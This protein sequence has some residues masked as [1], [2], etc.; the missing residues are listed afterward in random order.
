MVEDEWCGGGRLPPPPPPPKP[1]GG[2]PL[3][4]PLYDD[5]VLEKALVAL[6]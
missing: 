1:P 5:S 3:P 4:G 2:P 6:G